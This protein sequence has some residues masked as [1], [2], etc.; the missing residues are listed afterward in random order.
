MVARIAGGS[1]AGYRDNYPGGLDHLANHIVL[2]IGNIQVAVCIKRH[3]FN[4]RELR[5][6]GRPTITADTIISITGD[7]ADDTGGAIANSRTVQEVRVI[8]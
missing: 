7:G 8:G 3:P 2:R 1:G 4:V 5:T 6:R